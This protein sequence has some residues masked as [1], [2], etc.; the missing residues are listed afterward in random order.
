M[1]TQLHIS[2]KSATLKWQLVV[3]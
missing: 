2:N 1:D 3:Q